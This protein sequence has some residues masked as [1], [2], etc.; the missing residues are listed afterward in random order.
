MQARLLVWRRIRNQDAAQLYWDIRMLR[1]RAFNLRIVLNWSMIVS[2]M[3]RLRKYNLSALSA[4]SDLSYW[5]SRF[6]STQCKAVQEVLKQPSRQ[7]AG[8][9]KDF[10]TTLSPVE[11][12]AGYHPHRKKVSGQFDLL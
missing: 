9:Y 7:V 10:P 11:T 4:A 3:G 5:I 6:Q 8:I 12:L 2:A 1:W